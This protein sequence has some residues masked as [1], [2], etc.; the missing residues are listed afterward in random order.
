MVYPDPPVVV[1]VPN[2]ATESVVD[3]GCILGSAIIAI[4]GE[5]P[6]GLQLM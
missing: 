1:M 2:N 6:A 4:S 3:G 5:S